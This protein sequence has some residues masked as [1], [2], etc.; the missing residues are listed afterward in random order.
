MVLAEDGV[1]SAAAGRPDL[2]LEENSAAGTAANAAGKVK[3]LFHFPCV[4]N[5]TD[6]IF[7][8]G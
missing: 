7:S 1:L 8:N 4:K 6:I 3:F 5:T 2:V